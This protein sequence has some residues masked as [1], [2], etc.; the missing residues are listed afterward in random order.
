MNTTLLGV[1]LSIWIW[2]FLVLFA[3]RTLQ[4]F[5]KATPT[6]DLRM[7]SLPYYYYEY[8]NMGIRNDSPSYPPPRPPPPPPPPPPQKIERHPRSMGRPYWCNKEL[9]PIP[10]FQDIGSTS[11]FTAMEGAKRLTRPLSMIVEGDSPE[12]TSPSYRVSKFRE[13]FESDR[14]E[15]EFIENIP[16]TNILNNQKF[17]MRETA[18]YTKSPSREKLSTPTAPTRRPPDVPTVLSTPMNDSSTRNNPSSK[19]DTKVPA[20]SFSGMKYWSWYAKP[21]SGSSALNIDPNWDNAKRELENVNVADSK[22]LAII[23][24][25]DIPA[26]DTDHQEPSSPFLEAKSEA[27][28]LNLG[29]DLDNA[30]LVLRHLEMEIEETLEAIFN[31]EDA[32]PDSSI[33]GGAVPA[34]EETERFEVDD[35]DVLFSRPIT[36]NIG[37]TSFLLSNSEEDEEEEE[38]E[39]VIGAYPRDSVESQAVEGAFF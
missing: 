25:Y 6:S 26:T 27:S 33:D 32:S 8:R 36:S 15:L 17:I 29:M 14:E 34:V 7:I 12:V 31:P 5:R 10:R 22:I 18:V 16:N 39:A 4:A 35:G 13:D 38:E 9:P 28:S 21:T 23:S 11:P 30:A 1:F 20:D 24:E 37:D 19:T 3:Y 2:I